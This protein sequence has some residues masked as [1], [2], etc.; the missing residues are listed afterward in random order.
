MSGKCAHTEHV[1]DEGVRLGRIW[2]SLWWMPCEAEQDDAAEFVA[3][4]EDA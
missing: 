4:V 2:R 3:E 1:V